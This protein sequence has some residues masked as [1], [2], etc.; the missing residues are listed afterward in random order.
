MLSQAH[1]LNQQILYFIFSQE[2]CY[3][4]STGDRAIMW[5]GDYNVGWG[6]H[7]PPPKILKTAIF[8]LKKNK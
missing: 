3:K 6:D 7:A 5:G 1:N 2:Q 8:P 4:T